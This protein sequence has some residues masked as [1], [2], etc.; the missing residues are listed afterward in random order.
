MIAEVS[1]WWDTF[2]TRYALERYTRGAGE[3]LP[4]RLR[5]YLTN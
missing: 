5:I 1:I 2:V 4:S 3:R